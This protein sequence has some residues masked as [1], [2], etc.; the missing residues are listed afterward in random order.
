MVH[1]A[2]LGDRRRLFDSVQAQERGHAQRDQPRPLPRRWDRI[3][4]GQRRRRAALLQ[5]RADQKDRQVDPLIE[6]IGLR[7]EVRRG[8]RGKQS[9]APRGIALGSRDP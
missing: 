3:E 4:H 2:R 1:L 6:A 7:E 9:L 8:D 5:P